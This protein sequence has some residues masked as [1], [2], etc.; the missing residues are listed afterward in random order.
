MPQR[1]STRSRSFSLK[2]LRKRILRLPIEEVSFAR[3]GFYGEDI[4]ARQRLEQIG[5]TFLKGYHTAIEETNQLAMACRLNLVDKELR[6]FA[7]EGAAMALTLLDHLTPW[8][9]R[10]LQY[11][12]AGPGM[13]HVYM[14][15]VGIGWAIARLPWVRRR[16]KYYLEQL[17]SLLGWLALDG[18]G[19]HEGYFYSRRYVKDRIPP[20]HLQNYALRAFDQGLGRSIWFVEGADVDRIPK[21]IAAFPRSRQ[22]DLWSGV[23]LACAYAGG[24]NRSRINSLRQVAAPYLSHIAQ[25]VAFAAKAR[26]EAN[27]PAEHTA[28][29]CEVL[30][31]LS[32]DRAAGIT[33]IALENLSSDEG[34]PAYEVWRQ[35]I[36]SHFSNE[37]AKP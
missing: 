12:M 24:A 8:S 21:T 17:N 36:Q 37:V 20:H 35:R 15:H 27:N 13:D 14:V 33:D 6:G 29:A 3:R 7:Y 11:F 5:V 34:I 1:E 2:R 26:Q 31:G 23:G 32:A 16:V 30:C 9:R 25:G 4:Q 18:Y 19:F 22:S 10:R 28:I